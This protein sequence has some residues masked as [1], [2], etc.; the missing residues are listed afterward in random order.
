MYVA[1]YIRVRS[2]TVQAFFDLPLEEQIL[3]YRTDELEY[4]KSFGIEA[5]PLHHTASAIIERWSHTDRYAG[6][7]LLVLIPVTIHIAYLLFIHWSDSFKAHAIY[8]K[9]S[10]PDKAFFAKIV[11]FSEI[12][13]TQ[14]TVLAKLKHQI[15]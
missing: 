1:A 14:R 2:D 8:K 3:E 7:K 6:I 13:N 11:I 9:T 5:P 12:G 15:Y 10:D 4:F